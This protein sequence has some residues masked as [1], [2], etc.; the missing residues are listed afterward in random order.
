[1]TAPDASISVWLTGLVGKAPAFDWLMSVFVSDYFLPVLSF[2]VLIALWFGTRDPSRREPNQRAVLCAATGAGFTALAVW[3]LN[4]AFHFDLWPRPFALYE[5]ARHAAETLFYLPHDPSF[6]SNAAAVAFALAIGMWFTNRKAGAVLFAIAFLWSFAR[7][8]CGVHY[9]LDI[10]GGAA[11]GFVVSYAVYR[12][13]WPAVEPV[14][15]LIF[16]W[17][18][19]LYLS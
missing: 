9:P 19:R 16:K 13:L 2:L 11:I 3:L 15:A 5:S 12:G 18:K 1:V 8:Y 17:T 4:H 7:V 14:L 10:V 6:P